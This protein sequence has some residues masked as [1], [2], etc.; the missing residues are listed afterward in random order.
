VRAAVR[1]LLTSHYALPHLGGIEMAVDQ[2]S[3]ALVARG[4]EVTLVSSAA[5]REDDP[6]ATGGAEPHRVL[7]V[8]AWNGLEDRLDVPYPVMSPRLLGLLRRELRDADVLHA[9]GFLYPASVAAQ[10][11]ARRSRVKAS[12]LTEHVGYVDYSGALA[13]VERCAIATIGRASVRLADAVV[14]L[15]DKVHDEVRRLAPKQRVEQIFNGVDTELYRPAADGER[16]ELRARFG[17]G[18]EPRL[19]FVGRFVAKK[20]VDLA[21]EAATR[22]GF[23]LTL[24]GPG[25]A[26][27]GVPSTA[28]VLGPLPP[29][30]VRLLYRAADAFLLPSRGE[31]FPVTAQEALASGLP[32]I[33]A[34]EPSYRPHVDGAGTGLRLAAP[35]GESLARAICGLLE[36]PEGREAASHA[37]VAHARAT[38]SWP[39]AAAAHEELYASL[40]AR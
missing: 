40:I 7:R 13:A 38:Y 25:R 21:L 9:H 26:P 1:I 22:A 24:V 2:L 5:V 14:V 31:G 29:E 3:R 6:P 8:P 36:S 28:Q 4:H 20:G 33:L 17:W 32:V 12:V 27:A 39:R 10:V 18:D 35:E 15:N 23:P 30:E 19:L 16:A 11:L 37:A 34:D